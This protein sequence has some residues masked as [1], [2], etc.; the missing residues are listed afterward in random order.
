[1]ALKRLTIDG[2]GQLEINSFVA[3]RAGKIEAQCKLSKDDFGKEATV[4]VAEVGMLLAVD[5]A[6]R[7]L[8]LP[9]EAMVADFPVAINYSTEHM[10]DN[11]A[12]GLKNFYQTTEDYLPRMGYLTVGDKF[13]TNTIAYDDTE[14]EDDEALKEAITDALTGESEGK[15]YG[16]ISDIGAIKLSATKPTA[17]PVFLVVESATMPDGQFAVKL[18]CISESSSAKSSIDNSNE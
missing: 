17:G 10:Y 16:G 14:Y 3:P 5:V 6:T 2:Y 15:V 9:T 1:M 8:R 7:T 18:H 4:P 13:H 12:D 11:R